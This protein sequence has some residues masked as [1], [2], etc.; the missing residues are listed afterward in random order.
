MCRGADRDLDGTC[1]P[2]EG[3][4]SATGLQHVLRALGATGES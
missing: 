2:E 4:E 3:L 1:C